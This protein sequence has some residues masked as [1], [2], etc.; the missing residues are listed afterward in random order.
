MLNQHEHETI[1]R[2]I[3]KEGVP[4]EA[5]TTL[6]GNYKPDTVVELLVGALEAYRTEAIEK[7]KRNRNK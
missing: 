4:K 7:I 6:L 2:L 5:K 3:R 1:I